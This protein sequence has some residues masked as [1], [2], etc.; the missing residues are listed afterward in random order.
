MHACT[1]ACT[2]PGL[3][4]RDCWLHALMI[5][6]MLC[7][8]ASAGLTGQ[9][10]C[11]RLQRTCCW[12]SLCVPLPGSEAWLLLPPGCPGH[13]PSHLGY[14]GGRKKLSSA[15]RSLLGAQEQ[16]HRHQGHRHQQQPSNRAVSSRGR[17][18]L[19]G[20]QQV[21]LRTHARTPQ[22]HAACMHV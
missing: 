21:R 14:C 9:T 18:T 20:R 8:H 13:P 11:T 16:Q 15:A 1:R 6:A 7:M 5:A 4:A 10:A 3:H 12:L 2:P 19:R 17:R 22:T